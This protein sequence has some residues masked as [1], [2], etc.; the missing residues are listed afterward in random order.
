MET[1]SQWE[2]VSGKIVDAMTMPPHIRDSA[3]NVICEMGCCSVRPSVMPY[4]PKRIVDRN[5]RLIAAAP[6]MF[7]ML[8]ECHEG[9]DGGTQEVADLLDKIKGT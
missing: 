5:A 8:E 9:C 1:K 3:G 4:W 6:A 2:I 7:R